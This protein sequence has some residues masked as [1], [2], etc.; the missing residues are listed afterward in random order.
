MTNRT[1]RCPYRAFGR[2]LELI[3]FKDIFAYFC[4]N[5]SRNISKLKKKIIK[6]LPINKLL[7]KLSK[8]V[9]NLSKLKWGRVR[10]ENSRSKAFGVSIAGRPKA[11]S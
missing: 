3:Y 1:S 11:K 8:V 7:K 6:K 2:H 10:G 5:L 9:K 4:P